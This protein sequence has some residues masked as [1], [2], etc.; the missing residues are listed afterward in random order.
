MKIQL[1]VKYICYCY[2]R[3][4][5]K[6]LTSISNNYL[7]ATFFSPKNIIDWKARQEGTSANIT[8]RTIILHRKGCVLLYIQFWNILKNYKPADIVFVVIYH[9]FVE[10]YHREQI[11]HM[12]TSQRGMKEYLLSP[13]FM[14]C[15]SWHWT[16]LAPILSWYKLRLHHTLYCHVYLINTFNRKPEHFCKKFHKNVI[17]FKSVNIQ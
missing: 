15:T 3:F 6:H 4:C 8:R 7:M 2:S 16:W 9:Y 14:S 5:G 11:K 13:L 1:L 17:T 12:Y 10:Y